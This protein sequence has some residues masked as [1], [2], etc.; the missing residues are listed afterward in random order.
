MK[1]LIEEY[2]TNSKIVI[3]VN[4]FKESQII[5]MIDKANKIAEFVTNRTIRE[6]LIDFIKMEDINKRFKII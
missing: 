4:Q 3:V 1:T 6:S 5:P 2:Q